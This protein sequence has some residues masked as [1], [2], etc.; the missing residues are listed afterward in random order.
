MVDLAMLNGL[1]EMLAET[2]SFHATT[3]RHYRFLNGLCHG[4]FHN[5]PL[6]RTEP[7]PVQF[8][9]FG[10][11][12]FPY[13][14]MGAIDTVDLFGLDELII[15]AFYW[16]NRSRYRR[17][18]DIGANL[19]LHSILMQRCGFRVTAFEPDPVHFELLSNNLKLNNSS[20]VTPVQAAISD[21][22]GTMEFVR[23]RG[24]TT[25]SHLAGAKANP[26]GDLDR[27]D[28]EVRKCML[29]VEGADF[30]KIDAEGHEVT[31]LKSISYDRWA[32]LDAMVEIGTLENARDV[33]DHFKASKVSMFSQKI[34]WSLVSKLEDVPTSHREGSLFITS[35]ANMPWA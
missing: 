14:K 30:A 18:V 27:F 33:F 16:A 2:R 13:R 4:V 8:E 22:D 35:K 5:S 6:T 21:Q 28:V 20:S 31:I 9:P 15:F 29:A 23:V 34:G 7:E 32:H 26:Y 17:T 19:G 25:G 10:T 12:T 24:N 1:M 11:L 3:T